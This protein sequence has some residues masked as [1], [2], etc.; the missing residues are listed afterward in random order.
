MKILQTIPESIF[1]IL[2]LLIGFFVCFITLIQIVKEYRSK[3]NSSLSVGYVL[4]WVFVYAFW[5]LYGLRFEAMALTIT[6]ALA[7]CIQ[8]TLCIIVFKKKK[9]QHVQ[10]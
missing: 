7:L 10:N 2:G 3:D 9:N 5:S 8:I 4:G 1:E 6:N